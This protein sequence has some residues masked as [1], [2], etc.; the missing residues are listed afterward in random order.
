M[1][2]SDYTLKEFGVIRTSDRA[3]LPDVYN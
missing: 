3:S 2:M 1:T